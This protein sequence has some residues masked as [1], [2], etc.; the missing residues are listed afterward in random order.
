MYKI[1]CFVQN[2]DQWYMIHDIIS[3]SYSFLL[4]V[5]GEK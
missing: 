2:E 4:L 1:Y 5:E 3:L